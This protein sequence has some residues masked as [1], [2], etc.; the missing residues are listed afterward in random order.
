VVTSL[1]GLAGGVAAVLLYIVW[2]MP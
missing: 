2:G 1:F